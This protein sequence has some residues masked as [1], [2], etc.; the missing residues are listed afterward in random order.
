MMKTFIFAI[1]SL[2][3]IAPGTGTA[4]D[5]QG[6]TYTISDGDVSLF[7]GREIKNGTLVISEGTYLL[8]VKKEGGACLIVGDNIELV[9]DG[10]LQLA[11]RKSVV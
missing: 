6:K 9:I 3:L 10:T 11:D 8:R 4:R 5:L 7:D 1:C 2:F